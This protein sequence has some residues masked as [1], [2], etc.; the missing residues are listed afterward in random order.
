MTMIGKEHYIFNK[1]CPVVIDADMQPDFLL[2]PEAEML[3]QVKIELHYF[4]CSLF[5]FYHL[6][7]TYSAHRPSYTHIQ[8][9]AAASTS[10][11]EGIAFR[12]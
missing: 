6:F 1:L 10:S 3:L 11:L 8:A 12:T 2:W 7:K 9:A 4:F 5:C